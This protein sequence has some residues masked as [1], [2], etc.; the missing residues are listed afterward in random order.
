VAKH[1]TSLSTPYRAYSGTFGERQ[2]RLKVV[3]A[4]ALGLASGLFI[5]MMYLTGGALT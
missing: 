3:G 1:R 5:V 4:L 2:G